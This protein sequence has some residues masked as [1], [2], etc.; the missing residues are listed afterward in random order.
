MP[1]AETAAQLHQRARA[2]SRGARSLA[3]RVQE[4]KGDDAE[5]NGTAL[6]FEAGNVG[7]LSFVLRTAETNAV[8]QP[9]PETSAGIERAR[10]HLAEGLAKFEELKAKCGL[11]SWKP[12]RWWEFWK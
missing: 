1:Y 12:P 6:L 5:R 2:I 4:L 11:A 10:Q 3:K 7:S 9:G 8:V